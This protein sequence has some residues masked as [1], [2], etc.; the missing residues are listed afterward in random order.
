MVIKNKYFLLHTEAELILKSHVVSELAKPTFVALGIELRESTKTLAPGNIYFHGSGHSYAMDQGE[1]GGLCFDFSA[2][3]DDGIITR[4]DSMLAEF[5]NI[6]VEGEVLS[7]DKSTIT[8]EK[9]IRK[10][11]SRKQGEVNFIYGSVDI[12]YVAQ[13]EDAT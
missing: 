12:Q 13:R 8:V 11:R 4:F 1:A 9:I 6:V 7:G 10:K 5:A 3:K 2:I